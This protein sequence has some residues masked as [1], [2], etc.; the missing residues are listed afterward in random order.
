MIYI[1]QGTDNSIGI[2]VFIRSFILL[3]KIY[4]PLFVLIVNKSVLKN[5]LESL[6]FNY[7][8]EN[9]KATIEQFV[10]N[11]NFF[12]KTNQSNAQNALN[13]FV[14]KNYKKDSTILI[15]L[16]SSK[17]SLSLDNKKVNGHTDFFRKYYNNPNLSMCFISENENALL[18]TD[19]IPINKISSSINDEL[20][21][22]QIQNTI[23][24]YELYF[25]EI[26]TIYISGIN[27]HCGENGLIGNE[28]NIIKK[29]IPKL[30]NIFRKKVFKGP[31]PADT[32]HLNKFSKNKL[33][34]YSYHDQGLTSFKSRN[35]FIGINVTFGLPFLRL[36]VDHGT[37]ENIYL[38]NKAD[39]NG[40]H[41]LLNKA[42]QINKSYHR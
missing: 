35:K 33:F 38:K 28:D 8:L 11:C 16:P 13:L 20:I 15:T 39:I 6:G 25:N 3:D 23:I 18:L 22:N 29:S 4:H 7:K 5:T 9:D 17:E 40:T 31:Y 12:N 34:V 41:F 14:K 36:S 27:P 24:N 21:I 2:E 10:L 1:T 32:I 26:K 30:R 37:A 19:H 42:I